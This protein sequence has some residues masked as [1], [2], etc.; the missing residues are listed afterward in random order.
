MTSVKALL[1]AR[2]SFCSAPLFTYGLLGNW[3]RLQLVAWWA[4][5][6]ASLALAQAR[7]VGY[8]LKAHGV[9]PSLVEDSGGS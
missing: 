9:P 2:S 8:G 6:G 7:T 3:L 4:D 1:G 5:C